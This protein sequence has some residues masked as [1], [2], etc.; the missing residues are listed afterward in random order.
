MCQKKFCPR[1]V[2]VD[3]A[4][5]LLARVWKYWQHFRRTL[6]AKNPPLPSILWSRFG[7]EWRNTFRKIYHNSNEICLFV[8]N[9]HTN[10]AYRRNWENIS[11]T[12]FCASVDNSDSCYDKS[13]S[14]NDDK[15]IA[16]EIMWKSFVIHYRISKLIGKIAQ[17]LS[18]E[19]C[20]SLFDW[21]A[22]F[23]PVWP[24]S[25]K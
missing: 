16:V 22:H 24:L 4:R 12:F 20:P 9:R 13:D 8:A 10:R 11:K 21:L 6:L 2:K 14:C 19:S 15:Q 18:P 17:R 5:E 1:I 25:S 7:N 23:I 3:Q